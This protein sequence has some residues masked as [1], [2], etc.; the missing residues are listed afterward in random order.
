LKRE[1]NENIQWAPRIPLYLVERL[2]V[3]FANGIKDEDLCDD[4]GIRLFLR[5]ETFMRTM[6]G[7]V[8]CPQCGTVF[9]VQNEG[10]TKCLNEKCN[11]A[12]DFKTY[13][14]SIR[15]YSALPGRATEAWKVYY[16]GFPSKKTFDEKI[17]A[18]DQLIHSFHIDEKT[19]LPAKT[20]ASKLFRGNRKNAVEF[21]DKLSAIDEE[22]KKD[23]RNK[24]SQTIDKK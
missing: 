15:D 22:S 13:G 1:F 11:W 9:K 4:L 21:L 19:N 16:N 14:Q 7:E 6:K 10:T 2:Y 20:V 17:I 23:W 18:I 5:C 3:S 12:T 8:K 24:I